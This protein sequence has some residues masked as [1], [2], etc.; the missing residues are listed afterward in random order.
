MK[1]FAASCLL[2]LSLVLP[3][4]AASGGITAS[5]GG[6][7]PG[8]VI[9]SPGN[10]F[11]N[12]LATIANGTTLMLGDGNYTVTPSILNSNFNRSSPFL[13]ASLLSK[14][15][16]TI[17][18]VPGQTIIDG[19]GSI[20]EL[21]WISNCSQIRIEGLTF[22]GYTN[23]NVAVMPTFG[24]GTNAGAYLWASVNVYA[25]EELTFFKCQWRGAAGHGLQ[26]KGAETDSMLAT[27]ILST[28]QI[29]V[30]SCYFTDVGQWRTNNGVNQATNHWDGTAIVPTGWTVRDCVFENLGRGVEPYNEADSGS[31]IFYNCV[32]EDNKFRNIIDF[33]VGPAGSTNGHFV[34]VLRNQVFNDNVY[35]YH[36]SNF[37]PGQTFYSPCFAFYING[38]RGWILRDN[39]AQGTM[40]HGFYAVNSVSFLDDCLWEGN[41]AREIRR[42]DGSAAVG[43]VF[44]DPGN[45]ANAA[46]AVRRG[47]VRGNR[48]YGCDLSAFRFFSGRD[49]IVED[50]VSYDGTGYSTDFPYFTGFEFGQAGNS[51]ANLTNWVVRNNRAYSVGA[52]AYGFTIANNVQSMN[53]YANQVFGTFGFM[54]GATNRAGIAV[55]TNAPGPIFP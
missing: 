19:S 32:I 54:S 22:K 55:N 45:T 5:P 8:V 6:A 46:S 15:N 30:D 18:G 20:G 16:I 50:N 26:D 25:C 4:L 43:F 11:S 10:G 9:L 17:I 52:D 35:S 49:M 23:H 27:T 28:N 39:V 41:V 33:A 2:L 36:G 7:L 40:Q 3:G 47:I 42:G 14:T 53:F 29:R 24:N 51:L 21:L 34:Q 13:G 48:A 44:G 38:G 12:A 31:R 37:G 1:T